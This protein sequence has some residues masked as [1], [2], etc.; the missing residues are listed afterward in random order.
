[1]C[2]YASMSCILPSPWL[3]D[4][5][6][7]E[8]LPIFLWVYPTLWIPGLRHLR[9][10]PT[11]DLDRFLMCFIAE[12][13]LKVVE[14]VELCISM[15]DSYK[16]NIECISMIVLSWFPFLYIWMNGSYRLVSELSKML[17]LNSW[18]IGWS[19]LYSSPMYPTILR[20]CGPMLLPSF[21]L[22]TSS[23]LK[24]LVRSFSTGSQKVS[25]TS[26]VNS[27][28]PRKIHVDVEVNGQ[29]HEA[30][31]FFGLINQEVMLITKLLCDAMLWQT[32]KWTLN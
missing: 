7:L 15:N 9:T 3:P 20:T 27:Y 2:S 30:T 26:R 29:Q 16:V 14:S 32:G 22:H 10:G 5:L 28:G 21:S 31:N 18:L 13:N 25:S 23:S 8:H 17:V 24:I 1:M 6:A 4:D 11:D 12:L 19:S